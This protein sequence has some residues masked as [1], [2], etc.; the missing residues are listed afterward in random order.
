MIS[1]IIDGWILLIHENKYSWNLEWLNSFLKA[2]FLWC[3]SYSLGSFNILAYTD[4]DSDVPATWEEGE[5]HFIPNAEVVKL[6]SFDT[7]IHKVDMAVCYK[8][9]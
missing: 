7:L 8:V 4:L 3:F 6:K 5:A 9:S 1:W 2:N